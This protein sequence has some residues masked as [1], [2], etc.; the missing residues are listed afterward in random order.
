MPVKFRHLVQHIMYCLFPALHGGAAEDRE[1]VVEKS[2]GIH[3][4]FRRKGGG[5]VGVYYSRVFTSDC[6]I[7][8]Q[9]VRLVKLCDSGNVHAP[10][11]EII[12]IGPYFGRRPFHPEE[13]K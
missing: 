1:S 2:N 8:E 12:D 10:D 13:V 11:L 5:D 7:E 3:P 9:E 4:V 6:Q